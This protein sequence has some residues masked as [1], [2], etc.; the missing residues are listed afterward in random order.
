M[1]TAPRAGDA[2]QDLPAR[3]GVC[4]IAEATETVELRG[5]AAG[6]TS[7]AAVCD[8]CAAA[9]GRLFRKLG[10]GSADPAASGRPAT[11]TP[12]AGTGP[13][14]GS[15]LTATVSP[16]AGQPATR[17][18]QAAED[19]QTEPDAGTAP[20][21]RA[22][23]EIG[24]GEPR[25][26]RH[27]MTALERDLAVVDTEWTEAS[28][29]T[30]YI[31]SIAIARLRPDGSGEMRVYTVN[32]IRR[33]SAGSAAVHGITDA[34]VAG[35]PEFREYADEIRAAIA[36]ADLGGYGLKND[37]A[38]LEK[39]FQHAG[40]DWDPDGIAMV[41]ALRIWQHAERRR[42]TDA[43]RRFV[44]AP[45]DAPTPHD[46]AGDAMMTVKVL[47]KLAGGRTVLELDR[48]TDR[49]RV[50]AAG[51]FKRD[52]NGDIVFN[53]GP[54][55]GDRAIDHPDYLYWMQSKDFAPSTL[56]IVT[57]MLDD[58]YSSYEEPKPTDAADDATDGDGENGNGNPEDDDAAMEIPF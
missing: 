2:F 3:C 36:G 4:G 5:P 54:H 32:P 34:M 58:V 6:A 57:A 18:L 10:I 11:T 52:D 40:E 39:S 15:K 48:A 24:R 28:I 13:K 21:G 56:R 27:A 33:I 26:F 31:V 30:G 38:M 19:G 47:E 53:L 42:L 8:Y 45:D 16:I 46:A 7:P 41:D 23:P 22:A 25:P 17:P 50:D 49:S 9:A 1:T 55:R 35:L 51:K 44:G 12:G 14:P 37:I 43:Y 29:E 20:C